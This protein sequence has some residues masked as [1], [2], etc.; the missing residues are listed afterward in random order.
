[1]SEL[2]PTL[3][4]IEDWLDERYHGNLM[5]FSLDDDGVKYVRLTNGSA[6]HSIDIYPQGSHFNIEA[7]RYGETYPT[8]CEATK[9]ALFDTLDTIL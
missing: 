5:T 3:D 6:A 8:S 1:M 2:E 4:T 9:E 7:E